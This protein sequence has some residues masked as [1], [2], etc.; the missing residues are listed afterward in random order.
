MS[1]Y[2]FRIF[3]SYSHEDHHFAQVISEILS[4]LG[5]LPIWD[6]N[7]R[8]GTPFS[9]S[10]KSFI[11]HAH[12][13][14]PLITE[15][16]SKRP[17]VHQETGYAMALGIP[18]LPVALDEVPGQM[19]AELQSIIVKADLSNLKEEISVQNLEQL[20]SG[21]QKQE[22]SNFEISDWA[23]NRT[24]LLAKNSKRVIELGAYGRVRQ[25]ASLSSFS[26][27]DKDISNPIWDQREGSVKRSP[28]YRSLLREERRALEAHA[29]LAG[30]DLI[31]D[32][33]FCLERNGEVATQSRLRILLQFLESPA[34]DKTQVALSTQARNGNLTLVG[35][36]FSAESV[37]PRPGEGHRQTIFNWHAP[38]VLR[39]LNSFD[40]T[41]NE[42]LNE[43]HVAPERSRQNA[44]ER[45]T[46]ILAKGESIN[47]SRGPA[48]T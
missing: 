23:E 41:F 31:I 29:S 5:Y 39:T 11:H 42:C 27:A 22:L 37:S 38:S 8:P 6:P 45:V 47:Q 33:E 28:F 3:I 30:C 4:E 15:S 7:I 19:I 21:S 12:I 36:W 32:P 26:I 48:G 9:N 24:D 1:N 35:D 44:V 13:F 10:I 2:P 14:M 18:I 25:R 40:E 46:A 17:W 34:A 16:S 43:N 20:V